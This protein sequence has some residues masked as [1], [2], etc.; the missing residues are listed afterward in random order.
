MRAKVQSCQP[1]KNE[2]S[3]LVTLLLCG[4][5]SPSTLLD[6]RCVECNALVPLVASA[7]Y[8][9]VQAD[10]D[11]LFLLGI[12]LFP[13]SI[14]RPVAYNSALLH[15]LLKINNSNLDPSIELKWTVN[16]TIA[17]LPKSISWLLID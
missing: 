7:Y 9:E 13:S 4:K 3:V 15:P 5:K 17:T 12:F 6:G 1:P 8:R 11:T 2:Y 14:K 10:N 16:P